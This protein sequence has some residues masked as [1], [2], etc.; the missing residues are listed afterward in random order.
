MR[1][2]TLGR[3][4]STLMWSCLGPSDRYDGVRWLAL[5]MSWPPPANRPHNNKDAFDFLV[6]LKVIAQTCPQLLLN[7]HNHFFKEG[8]FYNRWKVQRMALISKEKGNIKVYVCKWFSL[9]NVQYPQLKCHWRRKNLLIKIPPNYSPV[10]GRSDRQH[11]FRFW[12]GLFTIG[13]GRWRRFRRLRGGLAW[14]PV[15]L[16]MLLV[17]NVLT[18]L[19][20]LIC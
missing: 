15:V 2:L 3:L 19:D 6:W 17:R 16:V 5:T 4:P 9:K 18:Q 7:M 14:K 1:R 11:G 20:G 8:A 13:A 10:G 12:E